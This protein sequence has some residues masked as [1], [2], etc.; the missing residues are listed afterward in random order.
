MKVP[1]GAVRWSG[2]RKWG[3]GSLMIK[4]GRVALFIQP[5][6]ISICHEF[7]VLV[8]T[9]LVFVLVEKSREIT[10]SYEDDLRRSIASKIESSP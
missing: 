9:P 8:Y 1:W 2:G 5:K 7:G 3:D 10:T 6:F 4:A